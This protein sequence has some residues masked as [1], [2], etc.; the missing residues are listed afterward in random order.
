MICPKCQF[1]NREGVK[2][3]EECGA[4]FEQGCPNCRAQIP[5]GRKFCGECGFKLTDRHF[6]R[7][8]G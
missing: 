6:P 8:E 2:F 5:L 3:C 4:N 1:E 7:H